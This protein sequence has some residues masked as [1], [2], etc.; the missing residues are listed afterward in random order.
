MKTGSK[1]MIS[2]LMVFISGFVITALLAYVSVTAQFTQK[3][4]QELNVSANQ[5]VNTINTATSDELHENSYNETALRWSYLRLVNKLNDGIVVITGAQDSILYSNDEMFYTGGRFT[6]ENTNFDIDGTA[7]ITWQSKPYMIAK[8]SLMLTGAESFNGY[9][10]FLVSMEEISSISN[11][12]FLSFLPGLAIA[13]II[14][15]IIALL[16]TRSFVKPIRLLSEYASSITPDKKT[17]LPN[18]SASAEIKEL[19]KVLDKMSARQ[20]DFYTRQNES[21]QNLSHELKSPLMSI[22]G[23]AEGIRD[24]VIDNKEDYYRALHIISEET[25]RLKSMVEQL[26]LLGQIESQNETERVKISLANIVEDAM[27]SAG[28]LALKNAVKINFEKQDVYILA[29]IEK[30]E[31]AVANLLTNCIKYAKGNVFVQVYRHEDTACVKICDDG[32]GFS[33]EDLLHMFER[34]YKGRKQGTGLGLNIA[35]MIIK[36]HGGTIK[37]KNSEN[38]GACYTVCIPIQ[39]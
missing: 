33:D 24:G 37:A 31:T 12:V 8:R 3:T 4:R 29:D 16:V 30:L 1:L 7:E 10:Y 38:G 28:G 36:A 18:I 11:Q 5:I 27:N 39:E 14:V 2:Y 6:L 9:M 35:Q 23:Y 25:Q 20:N 34:F 21:L 22:Q 17:K 15:L 19:A 13:L 26:L 32:K